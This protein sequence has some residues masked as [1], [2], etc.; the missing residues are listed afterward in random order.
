MKYFKT[1]ISDIMLILAW[2]ALGAVNLISEESI[3]H[4]QYGAILFALIAVLACNAFAKYM[5]SR[6]DH[7][8]DKK[9][10]GSS[11]GK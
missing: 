10:G 4:F 8:D 6:I 1:Y 5:M 9:K 11:N 3:T 7:K 2:S